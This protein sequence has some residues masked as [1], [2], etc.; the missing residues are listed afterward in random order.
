MES[1]RAGMAMDTTTARE[2][3]AGI[4][5]G[6]A[7]RILDVRN[8]EEFARWKIEGPHPVEALNLPYFAFL[9][10]EDDSVASVRRWLGGRPAPLVVVCAKGGSSELVAEILRAQGIDARN[11][12]GGM[13]AW[14]GETV[15]TPVEAGELRVW[16]IHRFGKG[17]LSYVIASGADAMVVDPHG[18]VEDYRRFLDERRL[19]LR[20]VF[21]THL[22][23]DHVSGAPALASAT[24]A[25]HHASGDDFEGAAFSYEPIRDRAALRLGSAVITP[26]HFLSAPGHTPGS[27]A[28]RAGD[29]LL[30]TGDTL[31]V[32]SV[33]RP[34][35]AGKA[36]EWGRELHRTLHRR[37]ASIPDDALV[38][39][40]HSG[41]PGEAGDDGVVGRR[42]G[43]LRR[44]SPSM[45][46]DEEMFLRQIVES[47]HPAPEAYEV[48][49]AINL[50][51][52]AVDEEA[53]VT[54]ELGRNECALSR[55]TTS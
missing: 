49:R 48:I 30:L 23:A 45:R 55:R 26:L 47:A 7:P 36:I 10:A 18:A 24:G 42:L 16:Q 9:E 34:D 32:E 33:G 51:A 53:R 37:L 44:A 40:A 25:V 54:M 13:V 29:G 6:A 46:A 31:F 41:G 8:E 14:G 22:H 3:Y 27:T 1:F 43:T 21:D 4:A 20:A 17:C 50:G 35:L 19:V 38:L 52:R 28:L 39:P 5:R 2:V 15:A 11:L 12:A